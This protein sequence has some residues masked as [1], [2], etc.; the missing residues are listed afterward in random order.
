MLAAASL[1]LTQASEG[2]SPSGPTSVDCP[3]GLSDLTTVQIAFDY[4]QRLSTGGPAARHRTRN[5]ATRVR[6]PPGAL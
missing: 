1:V 3:I 5:A 6:F 4:P 2:S